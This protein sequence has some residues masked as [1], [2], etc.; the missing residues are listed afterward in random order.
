MCRLFMLA[1]STMRQVHAQGGG[2]DTALGA[3]TLGSRSPGSFSSG[4]LDAFSGELHV[5]ICS[6]LYETEFVNGL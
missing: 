5:Y 1:S 4:Y 2:R 6:L 3:S